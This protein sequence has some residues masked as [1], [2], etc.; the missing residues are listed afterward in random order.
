MPTI[1][2]V[3]IYSLTR[4]VLFT[5]LLGLHLLLLLQLDLRAQGLHRHRSHLLSH[6]SF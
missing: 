5:L 1:T 4:F 6:L 2:Y 3:I